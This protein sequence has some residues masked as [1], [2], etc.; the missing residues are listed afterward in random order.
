VFIAYTIVGLVLAAALAG[1]GM[2]KLT[3]HPQVTETLTGVGVPLTW[4]PPLAALEIAAAVGLVV[5][6]AVPAIG[7]AAAIGVVLYFIGAVITHVRAGDHAPASLAAP[8][9][10]G[11]VGVAALV[12]RLASI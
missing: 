8:I 9:L 2:A 6:L 4:F 7:A 12:L 10:L 5:G 11:L 3:R 1:S